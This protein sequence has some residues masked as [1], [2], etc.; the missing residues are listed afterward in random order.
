MRRASSLPTFGLLLPMSSVL[1]AGVAVWVLYLPGVVF[2][3]TY[4]GQYLASVWLFMLLVA[5]CVIWSGVHHLRRLPTYTATGFGTAALGLATRA[6]ADFEVWQHDLACYPYP[7]GVLGATQG[8]LV[9]WCRVGGLV[10]YVF[11]LAMVV[12]T[13]VREIRL[14]RDA[15]D[16]AVPE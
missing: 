7:P 13:T 11:G 8:T 16:W 4:P 1:V 14:R 12:A 6:L 10:A 5:A 9:A 15:P 2:G 3:G